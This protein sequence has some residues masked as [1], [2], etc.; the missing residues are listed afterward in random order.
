MHPQKNISPFPLILPFFKSC[1]EGA[2]NKNDRVDPTTGSKPQIRTE[3]GEQKQL[4]VECE[5]GIMI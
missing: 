2:I 5:I 1:P 4:W 3:L